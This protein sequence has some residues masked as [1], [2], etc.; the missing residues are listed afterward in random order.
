M[1]TTHNSLAALFDD[2]ADA[3]REKFGLTRTMK[4]DDF[5][6]IIRD[7]VMLPTAF[8]RCEWIGCSGAQS[9]LLQNMN[10]S[11]LKF[12]MSVLIHEYTTSWGTYLF[13]SPDSSGSPAYSF[14]SYG[15]RQD[16]LRFICYGKDQIFLQ[17]L[18]L[19]Q[20]HVID[21]MSKSGAILVDGDEYSIDKGSRTIE[22]DMLLFCYQLTHQNYW[23]VGNC[24]WISFWDGNT[25]VRNL[26]PCYL[27]T[28]W[29]GIPAGTIGLYDLCGS[30][31]SNGTPFY[32]NAGTGAFTKGPD[33]T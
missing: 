24:Y 9:I 17:R 22:G 3:I 19:D 14:Q 4:A 30:L 23:L 2:I 27:K 29:N 21:F 16:D 26:V 28:A 11:D 15:S 18:S 6:Q 33:V 31:S 25:I 7:A 13:S 5:P 8:Q 12:K 20:E 32:T 1:A 10:Y